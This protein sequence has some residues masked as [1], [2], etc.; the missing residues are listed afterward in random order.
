MELVL[1]AVPVHRGLLSEHQ[2][3]V[4]SLSFS[5]IARLL[6]VGCLY[7]PNAPELPDFAQR[8][9]NPARVKAIAQYILETYEDGS[10]FF[11][12]ICIN[13][14]PQPIYQ[15][16]SI[17]LPYSSVSLRLTDGQHRCFGIR[18]ALRNIEDDPIKAAALAGLEVG[19]LIYAGLS[20]DQEKQAFRDQNL[21]VQRP[22]NSLTY[23]FDQRSPSV[24][25]AKKLLD[26]VPQF[27]NNIEMVENGLGKHNAKL[28]TFSTL[29]SATQQMFPN[30]R[31]EK[32]LETLSEW[33]IAFWVAAASTLPDDLWRAVGKEERNRQRQENLAVTAVVFQA[34]GLIAYDLYREG[35]PSEDLLKRLSGLKAINWQRENPLWKERSVTQIGAKG[36]PIVQNTRTT[37]DAC[38]RVLREFT[39]IMSDYI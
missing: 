6:D 5:D 38:H 25:I 18:Q 33:A 8:K 35:V 21:L 28:M 32:D 23:T 10:T 4:A 12:P 34:L 22:S 37:I 7:V 26:R 27:Q 20:L 11:P 1:Q 9:L 30:L 24:L 31:L 39:G 2:S 36:V 13:V 3:Y 17:F 14:Q 15:D 16:G 19:G 29:I